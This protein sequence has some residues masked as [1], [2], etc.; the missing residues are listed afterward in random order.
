MGRS[1]TLDNFKKLLANFVFFMEEEMTNYLPVSKTLW[2]L[3]FCR[4]KW[5]GCRIREWKMLLWCTKVQPK[6]W[7]VGPLFSFGISGS[8]ETG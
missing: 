1:F 3:L 4:F 2:Q 6:T 8:K 7:K 5:H